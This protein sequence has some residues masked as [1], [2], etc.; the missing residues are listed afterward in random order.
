MYKQNPELN[1]VEV[2]KL[3]VPKGEARTVRFHA[4]KGKEI[5]LDWILE[6]NDV[7]FSIVNPDGTELVAAE[8]KACTLQDVGSSYH[9]R[10]KATQSGEHLLKFDNS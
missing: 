7:S 4:E 2:M 3:D 6:D 5:V 8:K 10:V 1:R 9:G